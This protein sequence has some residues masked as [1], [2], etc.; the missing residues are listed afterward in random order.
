M[1]AHQALVSHGIENIT[2]GEKEIFETKQRK[3]I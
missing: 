3:P 2:N 1:L